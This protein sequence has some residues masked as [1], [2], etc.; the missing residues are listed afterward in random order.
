MTSRFTTKSNIQGDLSKEFFPLIHLFQLQMHQRALHQIN[1]RDT[2][3][4]ENLC[5]II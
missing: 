5:I 2:L 3:T 1:V 4:A